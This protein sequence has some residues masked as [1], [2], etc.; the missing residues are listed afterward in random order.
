MAEEKKKTEHRGYYLA[1]GTKVPSVTTII[2]AFKECGGLLHWAW[3]LGMEGKDYRAERDAAA[4]AGTLA[5]QLVERWIKKEPLEITGEQEA[6]TKAQMAFSAFQE[7]AKQ[8][9]M[10][11]T[12]SEVSLISETHKFGG[13]LDCMLVNGKRSLGDFKTSN[14][15]YAE[16]LYQ[17]AGYGILWDEHHPTEPIDGGFHL[18]KFS[19]DFPDFSHHFWSELDEAKEGFLL[20]RRLYTIKANL[21]KRVK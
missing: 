12:A 18:L 13:T 15:I 11:I 5:H 1:D 2:G 17:I 14:S 16:Y 6:V 3:K 8:S 4:S 19:K 10:E 20:M 9:R 21:N 7:W